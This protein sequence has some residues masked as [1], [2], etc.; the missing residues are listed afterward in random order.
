MV[1]ISRFRLSNEVYDKLFV[2]LF[3]VIGKRRNKKE[4]NDILFDLLSPVERIMIAKRVVIIYLLM[5]EIDYRDIC[6]VLK[7]SNG[8]V[9]KFRLIME[10]SQGIVP[11]LK[12]ILKEE[13]VILF[14][15]ELFNDLF[16]PGKYGVNW[17]AAWER[18]I[19]LERKKRLGI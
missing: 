18:R 19:Y 9:S 7:V 6:Q 12:S 16:P 10:K 5:K 2:L 1:R 8:T 15:E 13:K 4:F 17:K 14:I 3:E 11:A